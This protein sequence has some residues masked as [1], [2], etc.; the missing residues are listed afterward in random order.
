MNQTSKPNIQ[1]TIFFLDDER[2]SRFDKL[3][4]LLA[5][6]SF[7]VP[8]IYR[9]NYGSCFIAVDI[10][11][12]LGVSPITVLQNT[13]EIN[14]QPTW[15]YQFVKAIIESSGLITGRLQYEVEG[16]TDDDKHFRV[17]AWA[18]SAVDGTKLEGTWITWKMAQLEGWTDNVSYTSMPLT[19]FKARATTFFGNEFC[20]SVLLGVRV[21]M[22]EGAQTPAPATTGSVGPKLIPLVV[23]DQMAPEGG[24]EDQFTKALASTTTAD[25]STPLTQT[26]EVPATGPMVGQGEPSA[27]PAADPAKPAE[28]AATAEKAP[29]AA[30]KPKA[31]PQTPPGATAGTG[32]LVP[33]GAD[34]G[35]PAGE[36][37]KTP[38]AQTPDGSQETAE[39]GY[40]GGVEDS[41]NRFSSGFA[42]VDATVASGESLQASMNLIKTFHTPE[43]NDLYLVLFGVV[44]KHLTTLATQD[45]GLSKDGSS[46]A[47]VA[48]EFHAET[49]DLVAGNDELAA[50][51]AAM[52]DAYRNLVTNLSA[53]RQ[54]Q[55][56]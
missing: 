32:E 31:V 30:R 48:R 37:V 53:R 41:I 33:P 18:V 25:P 12:R 2:F 7:G 54:V 43:S 55:T 20:S 8:E 9:G 4:R 47:T 23:K 28:K 35:A 46:F 17:R 1:N 6:S 5:D 52:G 19:M 15:G 3:A 13:R 39:K 50:K 40:L 44:E 49:K 36:T 22:G 14:G 10:A 34:T 11:Y 29:R 56:A 26:A 45:Q 16:T 27:P 42:T 38:D 21:D 51:R 24:I